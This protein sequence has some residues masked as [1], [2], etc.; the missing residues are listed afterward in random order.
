MSPKLFNI[1]VDELSVNLKKCNSGCHIENMCVNHL[2]Y[3]DDLCLLAP[4]P[5]GQQTMFD[6]CAPYGCNYDIIYNPLKSVCLVFKPKTFKLSCPP[7]RLGNVDLAYADN[8][9]Y[10]GLT[11]AVSFS[12]DNDIARQMS[13]LYMRSNIFP[14]E[15]A[16]C[17]INVKC[18]LFKKYCVALYCPFLWIHFRKQSI[19]NLRIAFN[20]VHRKLLNYGPRDSVKCLSLITCTTLTRCYVNVS[21]VLSNA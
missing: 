2:F 17:S 7:I 21:M 11:F 16:Q 10:L 5:S 3:A 4:S 18:H 12:D 6:V 19:N 13:L 14:R 15:F 9:K 8:T 20:N 1:Y